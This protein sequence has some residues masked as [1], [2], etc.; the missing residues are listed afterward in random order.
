MLCQIDL[1]GRSHSCFRY[2]GGWQ[3]RFQRIPRDESN[4]AETVIDWPSNNSLESMR[5]DSRSVS[6]TF[7]REVLN[8]KNSPEITKKLRRRLQDRFEKEKPGD[9]CKEKMSKDKQTG[10]RS[11]NNLSLGNMSADSRRALRN[12][13]EKLSKT[14]SSV[15]TTFGTISQK[16]KSSTRRR[17]RLE[18]QQSPNSICKMQTPQTRS[19]QLLGRTPTKLYSPFGIESPRHAWNKENNETPVH[20]P[21]G[22]NTRYIQCRPFRFTR[23]KGFSMLR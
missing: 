20:T 7:H 15:R 23:A 21:P 13:A 14:I 18:E 1:I 5:P 16:F 19:R 4:T 12:G 9:S 3:R 2:V 6:F 17:Q 11:W 10:D 22:M 8:V